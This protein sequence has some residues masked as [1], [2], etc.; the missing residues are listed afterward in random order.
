MFSKHR[1][2]VVNLDTC[3]PRQGVGHGRL[4]LYLAHAPAPATATAGVHHIEASELMVVPGFLGRHDSARLQ[5]AFL[6]N[7]T[8]QTSIDAWQASQSVQ[9]SVWV[10]LECWTG[11]RE[12]EPHQSSV[13]NAPHCKF[14][15]SWATPH[16]PIYGPDGINSL[17]GHCLTANK[18]LQLLGMVGSSEPL[19][20]R[21]YLLATAALEQSC[22]NTLRISPPCPSIPSDVL[23]PPPR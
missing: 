15:L 5:R 16:S 3:N 6:D 1:C 22:P 18:N 20:H 23:A 21:H 9:D 12:V 11:T 8:D 7:H 2:S 19:P 14:V 4:R 17:H 13:Y 10:I